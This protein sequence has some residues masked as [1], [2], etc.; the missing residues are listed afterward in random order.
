[1]QILDLASDPALD[2]VPTSR[3]GLAREFVGLWLL[4]RCRWSQGA[5]PWLGIATTLATILVATSLHFHFLRPF[6]WRSGDVYATLPLTT[7]LARMPMSILLPNGVTATLGGLP[8]ASCGHRPWRVDTG[9]LAHH[10][11]RSCRALRFDTHR[12]PPTAV[13]PR[14]SLRISAR[15][16]A[17]P[18]YRTVGGDHRGWG[19]SA[20]RYKNESMRPTPR[21]RIDR[22]S[23][24][25]ARRRRRRTYVCSDF[26]SHRWRG[27]LQRVHPDLDPQQLVDSSIAG[28][29]DAVASSRFF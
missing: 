3:S 15:D 14:P 29:L 7:E 8:P 24:H 10:R 18:G 13:G 5:R 26:W 22:R 16:G 6:L 1:M 2:H 23:L 19:V 12:P 11:R 20:G 25:H 21:Y 28:T 17:H 9:S 4:A 27:R